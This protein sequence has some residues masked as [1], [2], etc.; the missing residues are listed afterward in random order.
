VLN[1]SAA[2]YDAA[3]AGDDIDPATGLPRQQPAAPTPSVALESPAAP[4]PAAPVP[5]ASAPDDVIPPAPPTPG[6]D[7][8]PA[9]PPR[10]PL[11]DLTPTKVEAPPDIQPPPGA[12]QKFQRTLESPE[13]KAISADQDKVTGAAIT[14]ERNASQV[15]QQA[16][17][18]EQEF[19][20]KQTQDALDHQK[21]LQDTLAQHDA[22]VQA[23]LAKK[24][25]YF[26]AA[27]GA[28]FHDLYAERGTGDRVLGALAVFLGGLGG[29]DN[30]AL[31][32]LD[33][34]MQHAYDKQAADIEA[35]WKTYGEQSKNVEA[36]QR[37]KAEAISDLNLLQ[38]ARYET[39]AD[40][41]EQMKIRQGIPAEQARSDANVV[42]IRQ[43]ALDIRA[44]EAKDTR[45][46]VEWDT[47][48]KVKGVGGGGNPRLSELMQIRDDML[49]K[50]ASPSEIDLAIQRRA[51]QL[52]I[53]PKDYLPVVKNDESQ[54][55]TGAGGAQG[56]ALRRDRVAANIH[57]FNANAD[58]LQSGV[59]TPDVLAKV[60]NNETE[61]ETSKHSGLLTQ[62]LGR[63]TGL[64]AK[65]RYDGL[66]PEQTLAM[67]SLDA[68]LQHGSEMQPS[69]G[70]EV[71]QKWR[72]T[73][74]P[75]PGMTQED[76]DR[77]LQRVKDMGGTFKAIIDPT[78]I[79][80]RADA[81]TAPAA[82]GAKSAQSAQSAQSAPSAA[83]IQQATE[84]LM[85]N[86]GATP[87]QRQRAKEI[88]QGLA[89]GR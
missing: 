66:T 11:P 51:E 47:Y 69:T 27:R 73:Y 68:A 49:K 75:K 54:G 86:S 34:Q 13:D 16:I 1:P 74:S 37:G 61:M 20:A 79:G 64:I 62:K 5:A 12:R 72:E 32:V 19:R 14:A 6:P 36:A 60:Q 76:I 78:N 63:A 8:A 58:R 43:K 77:S 4:V 38:S 31:G 2:A 81:A 39:A 29:G 70:A 15:R 24:Q 88:L 48:G 83:M 18:D 53:K 26:D 50:G 33:A 55:K 44:Q 65:S 59:I 87:R 84:A 40:Q 17:K 3:N 52:N 56:S 82:G 42:A 7:D 22:E 85:P 67:Q 28:Q 89:P 71:S 9:A 10:T 57:E 45:D 23:A 46:R 21:R 25:E 30:K 41:L 35:K 80:G